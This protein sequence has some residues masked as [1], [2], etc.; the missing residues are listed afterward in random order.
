MP[1]YEPIID[2]L[3]SKSEAG[4]VP[5]KPTYNENT[6]VAA[7]D[8]EVTFEITRLGA[9]AFELLM[10][11]KD[12]KKIVELTCRNYKKYQEEYLDDDRFFDKVK[13]LFEAARVT[14]L[15]VDKKLNVAEALLDRF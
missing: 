13:R 6:F 4:T 9:G 7:L 2:K 3:L 10:K 5:W 15:E 8:G 14:G 1:N 12:D 11:D